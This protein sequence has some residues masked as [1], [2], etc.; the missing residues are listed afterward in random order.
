MPKRD[1]LLSLAAGFI[2]GIFLIPTL[3]N[4]QILASISYFL[5]LPSIALPIA[6]AV[7]ILIANFLSKKIAILFQLAK[8]ALVGVL[9]TA[10]DFGI[11]NFLIATTSVTSGLGIILINS[12]SFS[13]ALVNS[14]FWNKEWVFAEKKGG[15]FLT[16]LAVTIIGLSINTGVVYILTTYVSPVI[17]TTDTLWANLAKVMATFLSLAWNFLGYRLIVFKK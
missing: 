2:T 3:I 10:I 5:L 8:F 9:N 14:Y 6:Y 4:T 16:F 17:V 13:T 15:N 11:L 1:L 12:T 7:G